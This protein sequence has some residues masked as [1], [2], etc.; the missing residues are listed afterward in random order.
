MTG[1]STFGS[2]IFQRS[3]LFLAMVGV[4]TPFLVVRN[5]PKPPYLWITWSH[6]FEYSVVLLSPVIAGV[7]SYRFAVEVKG[8]NWFL[9]R[10]SARA[11]WRRLLRRIMAVY[12]V[13]VGGF[14][15][16]AIG[17][18]A[19][20]ARHA[21]WGGPALGAF[22]AL[23]Y[24]MLSATV[25][26]AVGYVSRTPMTSV[27]TS[28]AVWSLT[29]LVP[30]S[31]YSAF[32]PIVGSL[33]T[34]FELVSLDSALWRTMAYLGWAFV[35]ISVTGAWTFDGDRRIRSLTQMSASVVLSLSLTWV[36][37]NGSPQRLTAAETM[38][39]CSTYEIVVCLHPA[40]DEVAAESG[41]VLSQVLARLG[42]TLGYQPSVRMAINR[43]DQMEVL[44]SGRLDPYVTLYLPG[45][46]GFSAG[47]LANTTAADL[48]GL[49]MCG[50]W[51][52]DQRE[53]R[54]AVADWILVNAGFETLTDGH[55]TVLSE[56]Q[57]TTYLAALWNGEALDCGAVATLVDESGR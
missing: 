28:L 34:A 35:V 18:A 29:V 13:L 19:W 3:N 5:Y 49:T 7:L 52:E 27:P 4:T 43:M 15:V 46:G 55:G 25:G 56:D 12:V 24:L 44:E 45:P 31:A 42:P 37:L 39:A 20:F 36:V 21:T 50:D 32:S 10:T 30:D 33:P 14:V 51:N 38:Q 17:L 26:A 8:S 1:R 16:G 40:W 53:A 23:P 6:S 54:L 41:R 9:H 11:T 48:A 57:A 2:Q 22:A 47:A